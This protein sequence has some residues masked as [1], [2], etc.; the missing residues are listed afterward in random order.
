MGFLRNVAA[1]ALL[2]PALLLATPD[3]ARAAGGDIAYPPQNWSFSGP[4]GT[5]D[6]AAAQRGFQVYSEVC[7]ACHA[8]KQ[9]YYRDLG[10]IG[11]DAAQI[12]AVAATV[13][14]PAIGDD[15]QP[16]ER[17][18]RPSDRFRAPY[19]NELAARAAF[20]GAYPPDLSVIIKA[21]P[22]GA[23]QNYALLVG[24]GDPPAG[25]T[26]G[27]GMYYNR[28]FAGH[29]IAMPPPLND[30]QVTYADGTR[31]S[32][33]QMARDVTTFLAY[34]AEPEMEVRKRLG[35]KV[36]LFLIFMTGITY[37]VKRK[38]WADAH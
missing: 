27:D 3:P 31:A 9:A 18:G 17:P 30:G 19:P 34:I 2:A 15:G 14:V 10:G 20:N 6:R 13:N 21:R 24:Y 37:A 28:Y 29:Q 7:A 16:T 38:V 22:G 4:F 5:F 23:D 32:V 8:L 11:L 25:Q 36:V 12:E 35:V 1:A 33:E 26:V